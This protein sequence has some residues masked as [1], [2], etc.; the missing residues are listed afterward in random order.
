MEFEAH[1]FLIVDD[2]HPVIVSFQ[3]KMT[4]ND[5]LNSFELLFLNRTNVITPRLPFNNFLFLRNLYP[6]EVDSIEIEEIQQQI[7]Q[8]AKTDAKEK[9]K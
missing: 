9:K 4:F 3:D 8:S 1:L 6:E 2:K 5:T 7:E